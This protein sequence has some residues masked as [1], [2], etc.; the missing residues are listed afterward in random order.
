LQVAYLRQYALL[1][2]L[3]APAHHRVGDV[4]DLHGDIE[5][6]VAQFPVDAF[7]ST[8]PG[9]CAEKSLAWSGSR[10]E[11]TGQRGGLLHPV[12]HLRL[13]ELVAF[14]DVDVAR[15][16]LRLLAPGRTS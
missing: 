15:V 11:K 3:H 5:H 6:A 1:E 8:T 9:M 14:V 2:E 4:S 7:K 16:S 10:R 12:R 13:V